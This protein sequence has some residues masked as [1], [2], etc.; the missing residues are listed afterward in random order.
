MGVTNLFQVGTVSASIFQQDIMSEASK[1]KKCLKMVTCC[2]EKNLHDENSKKTYHTT[3]FRKEGT[4]RN[5][6]KKIF[7][8]SLVFSCVPRVSMSLPQ[9]V[10]IDEKLSKKT[11]QKYI[12]IDKRGP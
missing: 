12:Q 1:V 2:F 10:C 7:Q 9:S 6:I 8:D 11:D 3:C 5:N 4:F